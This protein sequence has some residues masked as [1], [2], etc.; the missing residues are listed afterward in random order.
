MEIIYRSRYA[1]PK[2]TER[3]QFYSESRF[4]VDS[5]VVFR[6]DNLRSGSESRIS[7]VVSGRIRIRVNPAPCSH[8]RIILNYA[9]IRV[10]FYSRV[11][12]KL[13]PRVYWDSAILITSSDLTFYYSRFCGSIAAESGFMSALPCISI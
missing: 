6:S 2:G 1:L 7:G 5:R 13:R 9:W 3:V 4:Q 8:I 11:A 12:S 10:G